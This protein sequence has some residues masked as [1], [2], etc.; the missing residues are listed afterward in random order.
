METK[1]ERQQA[2]GESNK[3]EGGKKEEIKR[4][5]K[6][7]REKKEKEREKNVKENP[8]WEQKKRWE[9][10]EFGYYDFVRDLRDLSGKEIEISLGVEL[11][12]KSF[13]ELY[14]FTAQICGVFRQVGSK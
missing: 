9:Q 10:Q 2:G 4:I 11:Q 3:Q 8:W 7:E 12:E 1:G 6:E 5:E 14:A 13:K